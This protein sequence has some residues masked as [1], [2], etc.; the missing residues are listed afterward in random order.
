[1]RISIRNYEYN[2]ILFTFYGEE[3]GQ[4]LKKKNKKKSCWSDCSN[5]K[6]STINIQKKEFS[7][8]VDARGWDGLWWMCFCIRMLKNFVIFGF[9]MIFCCF[10]CCY[11]DYYYYF[12]LVILKTIGVMINHKAPKVCGTDRNVNGN[13]KKKR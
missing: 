12:V 9:I 1:M 4:K 7:E 10:S 3:Y 13:E 2:S 8:T 5:Q 11:Y 6:H